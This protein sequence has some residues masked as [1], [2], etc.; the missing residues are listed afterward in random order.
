MPP[1]LLEGLLEELLLFLS[2]GTLVAVL[3]KGLGLGGM[4]FD[5]LG[6]RGV[7]LPGDGIVVGQ[8]EVYLLLGDVLEE[9]VH[10]GDELVHLGE[11]EVQTIWWRCWVPASIQSI[12][13]NRVS[14]V[15]RVEE[16]KDRY[17]LR[18]RQSET[19]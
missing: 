8:L 13:P 7:F 12:V 5:L 15:S 4:F 3:G 19:V 17:S 16:E 2:E 18:Q 10:G 6:P 1:E 11:G 14:R 9:G